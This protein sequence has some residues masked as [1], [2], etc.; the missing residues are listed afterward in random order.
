M[1]LF[2]LSRDVCLSRECCFLDICCLYSID[3]ADNF[4]WLAFFNCCLLDFYFHLCL[5]QRTLSL[6]DNCW[7]DMSLLNFD[8]F[9]LNTNFRLNFLAWGLCR[10]RRVFGLLL[11]SYGQFRLKFWLL[12]YF[13]FNTFPNRLF[14]FLYWQLCLW[15]FL[16]GF[17]NRHFYLSF[18]YHLIDFDGWFILW[19][20]LFLCCFASYCGHWWFSTW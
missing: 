14:H 9:L 6:R 12:F 5:R 11:D 17:R 4:Y 2:K 7:R 3:C 19:F 1:Q 16:G 20:L 13:I 15:L 10:C 18:H 8:S